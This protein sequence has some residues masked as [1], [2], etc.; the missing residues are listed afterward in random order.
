MNI[1]DE[2]IYL[3]SSTYEYFEVHLISLGLINTFQSTI[4]YIFNAQI[5]LSVRTLCYF[6]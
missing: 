5:Y 1:T 6:V 2:Y 3:F 4:V